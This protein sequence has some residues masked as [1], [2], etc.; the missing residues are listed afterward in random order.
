MKNI[1]KIMICGSVIFLVGCAGMSGEFDCN[2]SSGGKCLP[3]DQVNKMADAG[4]FN[5]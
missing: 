5:R 3:T 1:R 4:V 2:V